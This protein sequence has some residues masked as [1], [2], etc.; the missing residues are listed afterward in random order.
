M[1]QKVRLLA[2]LASLNSGHSSNL[3]ACC[4][5]VRFSSKPNLVPARPL[6]PRSTAWQ[7][8]LVA[9]LNNIASRHTVDHKV[10]NDREK[11]NVLDGHLHL[12]QLRINK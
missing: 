12:G 8:S 3:R 11:R 2:T 6:C 9:N 1:R 5:D 4:V 10:T 7:S